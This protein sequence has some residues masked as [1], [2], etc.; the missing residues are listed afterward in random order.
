MERE[1]KRRI[2][3]LVRRAR[4]EER[5]GERA[6]EMLETKEEREGVQKI[7]AYQGRWKGKKHFLSV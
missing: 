4:G 7:L 2:G 1:R 3:Y 5:R 6:R